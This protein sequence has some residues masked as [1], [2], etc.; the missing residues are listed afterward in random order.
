MIIVT[1]TKTFY[2]GGIKNGNEKTKE[3]NSKKK[4]RITTIK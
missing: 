2:K 1:V 3:K 4:I